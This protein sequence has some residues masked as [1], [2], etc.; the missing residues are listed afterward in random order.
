VDILRECCEC[1]IFVE[2]GVVTQARDF[3]A[4]L[5]DQRVRSYLGALVP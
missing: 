4:L 1:F 5:Q 3:D 2:K